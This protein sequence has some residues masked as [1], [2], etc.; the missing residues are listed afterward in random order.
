MDNK[1]D[2]RTAELSQ[3]LQHK[4]G[5]ME[6]DEIMETANEGGS[7]ESGTESKRVECYG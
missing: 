6:K 1:T 3:D 4:S 7:E 5:E 2:R